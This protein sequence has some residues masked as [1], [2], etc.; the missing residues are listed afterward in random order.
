MAA[1]AVMA[2]RARDCRVFMS[3]SSMLIN[4]PHDAC[5]PRSAAGQRARPLDEP[6]Q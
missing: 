5:R 4:A 6:G 3:V 1:A 2:A